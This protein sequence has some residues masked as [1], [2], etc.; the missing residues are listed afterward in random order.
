M[1]T[2]GRTLDFRRRRRECQRQESEALVATIHEPSKFFVFPVGITPPGNFPRPLSGCELN[3]APTNL[4]GTECPQPTHDGAIA[5]FVK[6]QNSI[7]V[8]SIFVCTLENFSR[9]V[10]PKAY[11]SDWAHFQPWCDEMGLP[12]LPAGPQ[13]VAVY[14]AAL[15][16]SPRPATISRRMAA[17]AAAH[18]AVGLESPASMRHGVVASV[19]HG[20]RRMLGV[21]QDAKAPVLVDELR[22]MVRNL[23]SNRRR[24]RAGHHEP[25]RAPQFR[26]GP[27][28]YSGWLVVPGDCGGEG[29]T[30]KS[31]PQ[32]GRFEIREQYSSIAASH[33]AR[34]SLLQRSFVAAVRIIPVLFMA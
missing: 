3:L 7:T 16:E 8:V 22:G 21:A 9:G 1:P 2:G 27:A 26:H 30:V 4:C 33:S 29:G 18:K 28:L 24:Q 15:A 32:E 6:R 5:V 12:S 25:D 20:I 34:A 17:I 31:Q 23:R 10:C 13:T 19:W 14:I 11:A